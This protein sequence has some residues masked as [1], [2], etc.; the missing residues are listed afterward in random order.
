MT[1]VPRVAAFTGP[2]VLSYGFRPFFLVGALWAGLT[3]LL[4]LPVYEGRIG[5][6][7]VFTPTDWHAHELLFGYVAAVV[8]GFLLTAIPNWTGRLP[9]AGLPLLVLVLAWLAGRLAVAAGGLLGWGLV[10]VIDSAFLLLVLAAAGREV[11]AGRNWRN[12]RVL[13]ILAVFALA[14]LVFHVEAHLW[15]GA[16]LGRRLAL[17]AVVMLIVL[18]GGRIIPSFTRN[19]LVRENP[20]RLPAP[21]DRLDAVAIGLAVAALA[22]WLAAPD[23]VVTAVL[24]IGAGLVHAV[25]LARWAGDR[26][27]RD[28]L[29]LILHLGYAFVPLGFLL[30][31]AAALWPVVPEAAG[32]HAWS[33]GAVGVMTLAVMTRATRGHT[34]HALEAPPSTRLVYGAV[35]AAAALRIAAGLLPEMATP[36]L[37]AAG[38]AWVA[39]FWGFCL[40]YGPLLV[41]PRH[42]AG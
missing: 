13:V 23:A 38:L 24:L 17:A 31:A 10:A 9:L 19:W 6:D 2:A 39:A 7:G 32:I 11:I 16:M 3:V 4:W 26:T 40:V 12:L 34:G 14:N 42:K 27:G 28:A 5:L 21:F 20:G 25:R 30:L 15:G 36:L 35:L 33:V 1:P 41:R 22:A 8:T 29:V 37:W 18:I